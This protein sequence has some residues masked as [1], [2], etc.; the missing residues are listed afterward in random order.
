MK[1][2]FILNPA[3][4]NGRGAAQLQEE[5][6]ALMRE[7]TEEISCRLT[8]GE[9]DASILASK[10][11]EEAAA[12]GEEICIYACGGDGTLH[13]VVNGLIGHPNAMLGVVPVGAGTTSSG[14]LIRRS[15]SGIFADSF[16]RTS[17]RST[18]SATA[19]SRAG[20]RAAITISTGSTSDL[21]GI[22]RSWRTG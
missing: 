12:E 8:A 15:A 14:A 16:P 22:P 7:G 1:H 19:G 20:R 3:S 17:G 2:A 11:A 21:T 5:I 18:S 13:E 10:L 9:K 6:R 4:G